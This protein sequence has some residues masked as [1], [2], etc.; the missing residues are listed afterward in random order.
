MWVTF[1]DT[2]NGRGYSKI[3]QGNQLFGE[4]TSVD[5]HGIQAGKSRQ[6]DLYGSQ[7]ITINWYY[8]L[9]AYSCFLGAYSCLLGAYSCLLGA[10]SCLLGAYSCSLGA[11]S[12][13]LGAYSC[14]LG[15]YSCLLGAYSCLLQCGQVCSKEFTAQAVP[16][17]HDIIR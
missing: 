2:Q 15:A 12:C 3:V 1:S 11:Y 6:C 7:G 10:Y 9:G 13:L 8:K 17:M 16:L 5:L 4:P 14:L